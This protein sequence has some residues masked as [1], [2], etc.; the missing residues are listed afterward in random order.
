[1][2]TIS[3]EEL[4]KKIDSDDKFKLVDVLSKESFD[5]KHVPKS[6]SIPLGVMDERASIEFPDKDEEII[7]YC[8]SK[9]CT[10]S[11]AAAKKLVEMGYTNVTE[12]SDG[13]AG[14]QDAGHDFE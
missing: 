8:A 11:P 12:F 1:M 4:K 13:L 14:W 5:E 3:V 10:A 6:I 9:T 2:K 7:V